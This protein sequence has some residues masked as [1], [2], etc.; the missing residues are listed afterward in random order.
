VLLDADEDG[1][2][3]LCDWPDEY[4]W[5][6]AGVLLDVASLPAATAAPAKDRTAAATAIS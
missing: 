5:P 4:D 3:A 6:P 1:D 2:C